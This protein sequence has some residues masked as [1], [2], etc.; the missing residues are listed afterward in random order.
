MTDLTTATLVNP[1]RLL[2][3]ATRVELTP[4]QM[5]NQIPINLKENL[6][7]LK[8]KR[9]NKYGYIEKIHRVIEYFEGE[10][11]AE[12]LSASA[13]FNVR[14]SAL[15]CLPINNMFIVAKI[16][17]ITKSMTVC[18]HG[19]MRIVIKPNKLNEANFVTNQEG[20]IVYRKTGE[21]LQMNDSVIIRVID[22][23]FRKN[24]RQIVVLGYLEDVASS[25]QV[26]KYFMNIEVDESDKGDIS[27]DLN[28]TTN[29]TTEPV[30]NTINIT[31]TVIEDELSYKERKPRRIAKVAEPEPTP[32]K[33]TVSRA[34]RPKKI[35]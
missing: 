2:I 8:E 4:E 22:H 12:N 13:V 28:K 20:N 29:V 30:S 6:K 16:E 9:C 21:V 23:T 3:M 25:E 24:D 27:T 26:E 33:K 19:A 10:V 1:Y 18:V 31:K 11:Y 17:Q 14:Y 15:V 7:K 35:E 34:R 32:T 5:N